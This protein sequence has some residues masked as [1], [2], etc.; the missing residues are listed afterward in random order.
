MCQETFVKWVQDF[1]VYLVCFLAD[2]SVKMF[3]LLKLGFLGL[4]GMRIMDYS[5]AL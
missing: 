1:D 3:H 5:D 4:R 2:F